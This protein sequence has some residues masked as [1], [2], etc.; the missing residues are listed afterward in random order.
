[1]ATAAEQLMRHPHIETIK[2]YYRACNAGDV[3]GVIACCTDGVAHYLLE[4]GQKPVHG[5]E[6]LGRYW[7]KVVRLIDAEYHVEHAIACDDEAVIEWSMRWTSP[8]DGQRYIVH[9]TEWYVFRDELI[10]EI[11]AYYRHGAPE[12]TGLDGF[13]Y[14]ERGY[15]VI[16]RS[17]LSEGA[18]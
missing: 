16:D 7:R 10:S 11:R 17:P 18:E 12:D 14:A 13:P 15:S 6:H 9:G 5:A 4:P 3:D 1:M 2:R 8:Q